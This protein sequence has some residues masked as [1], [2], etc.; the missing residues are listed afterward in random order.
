M[1]LAEQAQI[2]NQQI[3]EDDVNGF[4]ESVELINESAQNQPVKAFKIR[5]VQVF[6]PETGINFN[7]NKTA[8]NINLNQITIGTPKK[9][10]R[11]IFN[12]LSG[13]P[14][15]GKVIKADFERTLGYV[16]L[17]VSI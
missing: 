6:D 15:N 11:V 16:S 4:S 14:V 8:L 7:S 5:V 12:D 10:W 2:D 17:I 3:L 9:N 1:N 13:N